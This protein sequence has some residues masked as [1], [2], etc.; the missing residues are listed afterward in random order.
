MIAVDRLS[1]GFG[2][3]KALD[4]VS[5][6]AS[7]GEIVGI[8]GPNGSGK[9]T[10]LDVVCGCEAPSSGSI[11]LDGVEI[12]GMPAHRVAARGVA[13]T[14]QAPRLF[15]RMTAVENVVAGAYLRAKDEFFG[16]AFFLPGAMRARSSIVRDARERLAAFGFTGR[17]EVLARD[18]KDRERRRVEIVRALATVPKLLLLD[19]PFSPLQAEEQAALRPLLAA[20][21]RERGS[22]VVVAERDVAPLRAFCDR[23]VVLHAG[24]KVAEGP[25]NAVSEDSDVRDAYLGVEWRQ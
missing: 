9:T 7:P 13:R 25:P 10:L 8:A 11:V 16:H 6:S 20:F 21:A 2:G 1:K 5:F 3:V 19:E 12:G 17:R 18:L 15:S 23:I 4:S 22:I 24:K 14:H